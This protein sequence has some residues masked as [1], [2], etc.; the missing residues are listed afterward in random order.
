MLTTVPQQDASHL[1]QPQVV[2]CLLIVTHQDGPA[3]RKP[4]QS[5]LHHPSSGRIALLCGTVLLLLADLADM[6]PVAVTFDHFPSRPFVVALVSRHRCWGACSVGSSGR[7]T[8]TASRVAS[9][10][11]KSGTFAP[12]TITESG[13]PSASTSI[14]RLTPFLALSV[15]FGPTR[16]PQNGPFP[17]L[18]PPPATRNPPHRVP[19]ILR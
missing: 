14:E 12:A 19:R 8:T 9:K 16:S 11:L 4:A 6:R 17:Y 10:S 15:G 3:L 1:D 5:A 7:S 2:G 18:H 13:P